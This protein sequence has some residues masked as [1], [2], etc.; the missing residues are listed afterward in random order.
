M[1]IH[2]ALKAFVL[3]AV[4]G[5]FA[6]GQLKAD[7]IYGRI[8][9]TV[10]DPTG[11]VIPGVPVIATNTA[12]GVARSVKTGSAG[13]YE[14]ANLAAPAVYTVTFE[15]T[16]FKRFQ[17]T[18]IQLAL[19]QI[20]VL[21]VRLELGTATQLVTV[22]ADRSQVETTSMELG[23]RISG[24]ALVDL[25]LNGRDWITLQ[26]TLP[27]VVA[28]MGDFPDNFSTSGSR[29][30]DNAFLI[31]GVDNNDLAL[32][33]PNA[34]PSPDSI[35]EVNMITNTINPEYGRNGGAI[36]NAVTKSGT[37]KFH[38]DAFE[39]YRDPFLNARNFFLPAPDQFHQNQ[40]GGTLGGPIWKNHTFFFFSY[41]GTRNREPDTPGR[42]F[43]GG[44]VNVFTAAQRNGLFP[45]I[46]VNVN[47]NTGLPTASPFPLAGEDG[48]IYPAGTPYSTLFPTGQIPA[49]D[50]S[51]PAVNL[52][53]DYM[54]APNTG[55]NT[56]SWNPISVDK[57]YQYITRLDHTFSSKDSLAGY[58]FIENASNV[59]DQ[60]FDGGSLPGFAEQQTVR[61]QNLSL[62]WNHTFGT[63]MINEAR[64]G[65]NRL[66]FNTINPVK[67]VL[68]STVGFD[69]NPQ[70]GP[71]RAGLPC[72]DMNSYEPPSGACEF[73]FSY[74]GPQPRIDQTYQVSDNFT[75]ITGP[76]TFKLGF[77]MRRAEVENPFYFVNNGYFEFYGTGTFSTGD[78]GADFLL[79]I[80]DLFEQT[81][82]GFIDARTQEYYSYFQDQWKV[83]PNLTLT[84]GGGWQINTPQNDIFNGGVA[85]NAYRPGVLSTVYPTAPPGLLFPGDQGLSVSTYGSSLRHFAPRL[86]FAWSPDS[87]RKWSIRG[88]FGIYYNQIEEEVTLQ[89]LQSPPFSLTDFGVG[90]VG[91][92]PGLATPY[93]GYVA[94]R[95]PTTGN[96]VGVSTATLSNR[97]PYIP[98]PPGSKNV[99]F[100]FFY[101]MILKVFDPNL[102]TPSAYNYN[103]T[104][105][106]ELPAATIVQLGY[107][108]HQGRHLEERDSIDPAGQAPG[109]NPVCAADPN[110][111]FFTLGFTE[112]QT[113]ANPLTVNG[114]PAFGGVGVQ[115]TDANSNY[116]SLQISVTKKTTHGMEFLSSYTWSHS[117]DPISSL[118]NVGGGG[119]LNPFNRQDNYG[120]SAYDA[121]QRFVISY[122]Y[123]IPSIRRYDSFRRVPSRLVEGWRIAGLTIL[124]SGFPISLLDSSNNSLTCWAYTGY[125]C[126]DRP[127][128]L[129]PVQTYDPRNTN[130]VNATH[131]G[132]A[133]L[134]HYYFNPNAFTP[135]VRGMLGDAG[136]NFFHGPGIS[137]FDFAL[138]KDTK[139]TESTKIELRFEVFN[140]FNH[141]QFT[142]IGDD[143]NTTFLGRAT[144]ALDPRIIQLAAKFYF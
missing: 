43:A 97:F 25:P 68:P 18:S 112:P 87:A 117:L 110:C 135:E 141:T 19:N 130:L 89:N 101:P 29:A 56:F 59:D 129:G 6:V 7:D 120:D 134:S 67:P 58:W 26:Q 125:G 123:Q 116:N 81:S 103:F 44:T 100:S 23:A 40:F 99:D 57:E 55:T 42:S 121:R 41:Q 36:M 88:G 10:T 52:I 131:G 16:G 15:Q 74:Q 102:T 2:P 77:D 22:E 106:R 105:Q 17:A 54:P 13:N 73:G 94:Q 122:S 60:S 119:G 132:A 3:A 48:N 45:D 4:I 35:A 126:A 51:T 95:D 70:S 80:P 76:H 11:A 138:Y 82:G 37:N 31:N 111:G 86:G 14:F 91:G 63:N 140:L 85:V 72:I 38:G 143:I 32:N 75:W 92:D 84:Y 83:R 90:D 1:L 12:T 113:L 96:I 21:D 79:G 128:V 144:A 66:G 142:S 8:R 104:I 53:K 61:T 107:V 5:L 136:R 27:G 65:Y 71:S 33:T 115:A 118:E 133:P 62:T 98:P 139:I 137:N 49:A 46:N 124:Q 20:Y 78:E 34:I 114:T 30:Q 109:V 64:V 108:G 47:P 69:I 93:S 39:F 24:S 127:N 28:S 9:G 50:F